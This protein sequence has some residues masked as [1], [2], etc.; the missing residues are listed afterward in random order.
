MI[1]VY[2]CVAAALLA[3]GAVIGGIAVVSLGIN[4]DDRLGGFP[5]STKSRLARAARRVTGAGTRSLALAGE[6][7]RRQD[8]LPG[9]ADRGTRPARGRGIS[10]KPNS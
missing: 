3:A 2:V 6:A 10:R 7:S 1:E 8:V 5:Y 9:L 4:R